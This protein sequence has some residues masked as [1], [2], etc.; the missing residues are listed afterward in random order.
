MTFANVDVFVFLE[1]LLYTFSFFTGIQCY[2]HWLCFRYVSCMSCVTFSTY[3]IS[4][5][6]CCGWC[7]H[8]V[9]E[10]QMHCVAQ[11]RCVC[12]L[13]FC[14]VSRIAHL[15]LLMCSGVLAFSIFISVASLFLIF[16]ARPS[17][18]TCNG[19]NMRRAIKTER[20]LK[21]ET[22]GDAFT[23]EYGKPCDASTPE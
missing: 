3:V 4:C 14:L 19:A 21:M 20:S 15:C 7:V 23:P 12:C 11:Y 10:W 1:C 6:L 17:H 5:V 22:C 18:R 13:K 2:I 9:C 8:I 16:I